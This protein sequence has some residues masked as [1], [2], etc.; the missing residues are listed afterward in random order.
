M[1]ILQY[2]NDVG[3]Q[4]WSSM[5][6]S[7]IIGL[8]E[9]VVLL[10]RV[11]GFGLRLMNG[12]RDV[13][14]HGMMLICLLG[15]QLQH[16]H[17]V[18]HCLIL[19]VLCAAYIC[20]LTRCG[21]FNGVFEASMYCLY[22]EL[23]KSLC[24][25]GLLA[26]WL[27]NRFAGLSAGAVN[28]VLLGLY[29]VYLAALCVRV[30]RK[31]QSPG[32]DVPVTLP[33]AFGLLFP[34]FLYLALRYTQY[35][36]VDRLD[37]EQW[38]YYDVLL[39]A[40]AGC[41]LLAMNARESLLAAQNQLNELNRRQWLA[42]ERLRQYEVQRREMEYIDRRY[43]DLKH[44]VSGIEALLNG[45]G[46]DMEQ[47]R[48]Y[49]KELQAGIEPYGWFQ[50]TGSTVLDAMLYQ[51]KRECESR[52]IRLIAYVDGAK[53]GFINALDMSALFG[54]AMDNAIEAAQGLTDPEKREIRVKIGPSGGLMLM[55]F[56]NYYEGP[57]R[58][59]GGGF[60]T[61]KPD[62]RGHGYGLKNIE[63]TAEKYG[64]AAQ[65]ECTEDEFTLN[66]MLPMPEGE[67]T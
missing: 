40:V 42:D 4:F 6:V 51:K 67:T 65:T 18:M 41:A 12:R 27:T 44:T 36:Q 33:Q 17:I 56:H 57:R 58:Q 47:A 45:A 59:A 34:L 15:L 63:A 16:L 48:A 23:G 11:R 3:R 20:L 32:F 10:C 61:T 37:N 52:S 30:V 50:K 55:V 24:R 26:V 64:G 28:L 9:W 46:S 35:G 8:A 60:Q 2:M 19:L 66:V 25:D 53:T 43:H 1:T 31:R 54:N 29:L 38:F 7:L 21:W 14:V 39:Y 13:S 5:A 49:I 62:G 22:I